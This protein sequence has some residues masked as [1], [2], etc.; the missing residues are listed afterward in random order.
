[1]KKSSSGISS[2]PDKAI[3]KKI[4]ILN[5]IVSINTD[6]I[7]GNLC[8]R[9]SDYKDEYKIRGMTKSVKK[10]LNEKKVLSP[11]R[12]SIPIICDATGPVY[13]CGFDVC[14]RVK[15]KSTDK[16]ITLINTEFE[17][18]IFGDRK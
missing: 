2:L 10:L 1:V 18:N 3:F 11:Y 16:N 14:D 4:N 8:V 9:K 7:N 5:K 17:H 15:A 12:S 13:L 6:N